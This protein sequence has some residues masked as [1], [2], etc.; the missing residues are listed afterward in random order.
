M[1][2]NQASSTT[3]QTTPYT[4]G[5]LAHQ[6]KATKEDSTLPVSNVS[7]LTS[8][9]MK[10]PLN[11]FPSNLKQD[12]RISDEHIVQVSKAFGNSLKSYVKSNPEKHIAY[13][14][15]YCEL[16]KIK[17]QFTIHNDSIKEI[18]LSRSIE[19]L[20]DTYNTLLKGHSRCGSMFK[21]LI[22]PIKDKNNI[23]YKYLKYSNGKVKPAKVLPS[24]SHE[25]RA[26]TTFI[27]KAQNTR[28][29]PSPNKV[30]DNLRRL[31]FTDE[32]RTKLTEQLNQ[33]LSDYLFKGQDTVQHQQRLQV[34]LNFTDGKANKYL[35]IKDGSLSLTSL[36]DRQ[37]LKCFLDS[38]L[39]NQWGF[40]SKLCLFSSTLVKKVR[41]A[42]KTES[43]VLHQ[44]L[45]WENDNKLS[46]VEP[47]AEELQ[48][49][50]EVDKQNHQIYE[51]KE[52]VEISEKIK[53]LQEQQRI[54]LSR[55]K[56]SRWLQTNAKKNW[57]EI[58]FESVPV[59]NLEYV[60][61]LGCES[62]F[63][64]WDQTIISSL[65]KVQ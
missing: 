17:G 43:G 23:L 40:E 31:E 37:D 35:T 42:I 29:I 51:K 13:L 45:K 24:Q 11:H 21:S 8:V 59:T 27:S 33:I 9:D 19:N 2:L 7:N 15:Y 53:L 10:A 16:E 55:T 39:S 14:N 1:S 62:I 25:E 32:E 50:E 52:R 18:R 5:L 20:A 61:I 63:G 58:N 3:S 26:Y 64:G 49:Y 34:K 6:C 65:D 22:K 36:R 46:T 28:V 60:D 30:E 56:L 54:L 4:V 48:K 44:Y 41:E 57:S 38:L 12:F 47:S